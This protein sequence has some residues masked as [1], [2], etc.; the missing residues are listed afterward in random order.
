MS[1]CDRHR[2]S[3]PSN[4][5]CAVCVREERDRLRS[6]IYSALC[7]APVGYIPT[8]DDEHL[9]QIVADL[10]E[11]A[12]RCGAA[13]DE[14]DRLKALVKD[15]VESYDIL[16]NESPLAGNDIARGVIRGAFIGTI[17]D[18]RKATT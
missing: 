10:S 16:H 4:H 9:A 6:I 7:A 8:H 18:A 11:T 5:E 12:G 15:L 3:D 14:R 1:L 13:E 2:I 17:D